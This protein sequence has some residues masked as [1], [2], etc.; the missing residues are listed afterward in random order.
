MQNNSENKHKIEKADVQGVTVLRLSGPWD[1]QGFEDLKGHIDSHIDS[2]AYFLMN[3]ENVKY[4]NSIGIAM[5]AKY[6]MQCHKRSVPF[7]I[8]SL[9]EQVGE[10]FKITDVTKMIPMYSDEPQAVE[11]LKGM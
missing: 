9:S 7:A 1:F 5:V 3:F 11:A 10:V 8:C 6:Y 4:I 2:A